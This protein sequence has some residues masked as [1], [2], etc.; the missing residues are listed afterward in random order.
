MKAVLVGFV[1]GM[2]VAL[3]WILAHGEGLN[4]YTAGEVVGAG[5]P[6]A[7]VVWA[8]ASAFRKLRN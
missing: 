1:L 5:V 3:V 6:G 7:V 8:I 4:P 2:L